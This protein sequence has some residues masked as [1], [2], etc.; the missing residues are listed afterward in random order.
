MFTVSL[1]VVAF[2]EQELIGKLLDNFLGQTYPKSLTEIVL[3]DSASTDRTPA[4][5]DSMSS[6]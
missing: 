3:V 5:R 4:S 6:T 1:C 2:N